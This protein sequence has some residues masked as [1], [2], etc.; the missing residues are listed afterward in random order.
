MNKNLLNSYINHTPNLQERTC[1]LYV[2]LVICGI[3]SLVS[4]GSWVA[5]VILGLIKGDFFFQDLN[6]AKVRSS[7]VPSSSVRYQA[8]KYQALH[9]ADA[10][11]AGS[12]TA[13]CSLCRSCRTAF[14]PH[15]SLGGETKPGSEVSHH[16]S[17]VLYFI[18]KEAGASCLFSKYFRD[19]ET[20]TFNHDMQHLEYR[21]VLLILS[22]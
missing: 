20:K 2:A 17:E 6:K 4:T 3:S 21:S 12:G 1:F 19:T 9:W 18:Q 13:S 16:Q 5:R 10:H 14:L 15:Q 8:W 7:L 22:Q 11:T